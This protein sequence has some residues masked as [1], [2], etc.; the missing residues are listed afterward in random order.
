MDVRVRQVSPPLNKV[1]RSTHAGLRV[2]RFVKAGFLL[3][4]F[5]TVAGCGGGQ[6]KATVSG[7][8]TYNDKP[9]PFGTVA[10]Y[11]ANNQVSSAGTDANGRYQATNVPV[12][13]VK[14]TVTTSLPSSGL[15]KAAKQ[16]K[17]RFGRGNPMPTSADIV[18]VPTKYSDPSTSGLSLTVMEGPQPFDIV[19]K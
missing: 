4:L 3:W 5:I 17:K 15:E 11:G 7:T 19:L 9:V 12:G 14:I 2:I 8:V 1:S 6:P 16:M 18:S 13:L 10:F